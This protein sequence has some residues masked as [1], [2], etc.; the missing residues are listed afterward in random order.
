V[1][2]EAGAVESPIGPLPRPGDIDTTGIDVSPAV[3]EELLAVDHEGWRQA[4]AAQRQFLDRFGA[5][6]PREML[7]ENDALLGRLG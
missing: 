6:M 1:H 4:A 5:R 7:A 3:F 2:G